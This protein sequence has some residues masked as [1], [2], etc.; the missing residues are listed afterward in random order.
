M[1][2]GRQNSHGAIIMNGAMLNVL[3]YRPDIYIGQRII[4]CEWNL[5][6]E[7]KGV[8]RLHTRLLR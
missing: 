6:R 1:G 8:I 2:I 4:I 5:I 3:L 7:R